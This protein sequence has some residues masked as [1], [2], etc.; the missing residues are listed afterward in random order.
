MLGVD[1]ALLILILL[2]Q[3]IIYPAFADVERGV[4]GRF[5]R[6]YMRRIS[7]FVVPLMTGQVALH[8][9]NAWSDRGALAIIAASLVLA[10]WVSTWVLS[11][12]AHDRL[13]AK[14]NAGELVDLL[15]RANWPRTLMWTGVASITMYRIAGVGG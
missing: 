10:T 12:P 4:F 14:G 1:V 2:V 11:V 3:F 13:A 15:V 6:T 7:F 5:H 9:W 8:T